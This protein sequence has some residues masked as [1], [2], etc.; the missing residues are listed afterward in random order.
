MPNHTFYIEIQ[1]FRQW[2]LL[3]ILCG[4]NGIFLLG[5]YKQIIKEQPFGDHPMS[6]TALLISTGIC[7]LLSLFILLIELNTQI[8]SDGIYIRFFP[9]HLTYR[10]YPW[11]SISKSYVRK[12]SP[13]KTYGGWGYRLGIN[14]EKVYSISG[15]RGLQLEFYNTK[16]LLIGTKRPYELSRVLSELG[17]LKQ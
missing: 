6:N 15:N 12:Y 3:L 10:F 16:S 2:W 7:I 8:R 9:F 5:I 13:L 11:G 17:Q 1:R 14:G 4:V